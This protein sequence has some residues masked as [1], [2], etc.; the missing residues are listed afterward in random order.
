MGDTITDKALVQIILNGL[1]RSY[2]ST[3]QTITHQREALSF[4]EVVTSILAE[5]ARRV[6]QNQQL[7][8]EDALVVTYNRGPNMQPQ[9]GFN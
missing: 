6:Q 7:S 9:R 4:D 3:I 8:D 1:P 5:S 2:E